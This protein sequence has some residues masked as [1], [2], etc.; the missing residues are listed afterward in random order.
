MALVASAHDTGAD[1]DG[2]DFDLWPEYAAATGADLGTVSDFSI[3]VL[4]AISAGTLSDVTASGRT[5]AR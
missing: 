4:V 2:V 5:A 1:L 3:A